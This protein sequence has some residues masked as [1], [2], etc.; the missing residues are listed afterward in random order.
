MQFASFERDEP[1]R[2]SITKP[3]ELRTCA[4][5]RSARHAD[6]VSFSRCFS[7]LLVVRTGRS[8]LTSQFPLLNR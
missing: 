4:L 7:L 3:R 2:T 6:I 8:F 5:A 1:D